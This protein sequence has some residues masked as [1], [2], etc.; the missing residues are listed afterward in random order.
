MDASGP[1]SSY[2]SGRATPPSDTHRMKG[3]STISVAMLSAL[4]TTVIAGRS[5]DVA[6]SDRA[7]SRRAVALVV[8]PPLKPTT[9]PSTARSAAAAATRS[10]GESPVA[11]L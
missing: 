5:D 10:F 7:A 11:D 3:R 8:V 6:R 1:E 9:D 2:D 4:V